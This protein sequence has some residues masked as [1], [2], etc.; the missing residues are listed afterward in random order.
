MRIMCTETTA[1]QKC[2]K[3]VHTNNII[4]C[5][6]KYCRHSTV[7]INAHN[8]FIFTYMAIAEF[9]LYTQISLHMKIM[10]LM[11]Y[12]GSKTKATLKYYA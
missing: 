5:T 10:K 11:R 8:K 3:I 6:Y 7:E 1:K 9:F 12:I 2:W 4:E